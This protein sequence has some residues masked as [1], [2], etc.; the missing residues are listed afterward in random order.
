MNLLLLN[1][2]LFKNFAIYIYDIDDIDIEMNKF[3]YNTTLN[4]LWKFL[5]KILYIGLGSFDKIISLKFHILIKLNIN[6]F[7]F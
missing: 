4:S 6:K 3:V 7:I 2:N 5:L 1:L